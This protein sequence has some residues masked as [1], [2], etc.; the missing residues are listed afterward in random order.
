[1]PAQ[2]V[3]VNDLV[4]HKLERSNKKL[5]DEMFRIMKYN[6]QFKNMKQFKRWVI[7][8]CSK[9]IPSMLSQVMDKYPNT[10]APVKR[11]YNAKPKV[12]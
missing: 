9:K 2:S 6:K 1:M 11:K 5:L 3:I 10:P 4:Y 8:E 7:A 12:Q